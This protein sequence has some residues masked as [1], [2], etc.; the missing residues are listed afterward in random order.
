MKARMNWSK[1]ASKAKKSQWQLVFLQS[2]VNGAEYRGDRLP[3]HRWCW[4]NR[5]W[6][7]N[8]LALVRKLAREQA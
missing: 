4:P 3:Q 5:T 7:Q 1:N 2:K 6:L 8:R